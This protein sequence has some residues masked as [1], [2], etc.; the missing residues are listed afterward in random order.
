M[1]K[2]IYKRAETLEKQEQQ[3]IN[4]P[5]HGNSSELSNLPNKRPPPEGVGPMSIDDLLKPVPRAEDN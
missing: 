2:D 4:T 3:A 1:A 5:K